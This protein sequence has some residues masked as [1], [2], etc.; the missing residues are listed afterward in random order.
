ML[1]PRQRWLAVTVAALA[2]ALLTARLGWWQLDRAAQKWAVQAA[3]DERSRLPAIDGTA[4]LALDSSAAVDQVHHLLQVSGRWSAAHTVF[5][6]NRQMK[7]RPGFY[8]V[9]PLL[10][11]DGS[12]LLVQRGWLPRDF[13]QRSRIAVVP[14]PGGELLA[15]GRIA[16]PPAR[17]YEFGAS[18]GGAI[19]QNIDLDALARETGLRLRPMS[20]LLADSPAS[21]GDGLQRDWPV[22]SSGMA[23][24]RGYAVQWFS[25]SA[26][27]LGLYVWFQLVRPRRRRRS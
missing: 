24:N 12:A 19:R 4:Q 15:R 9:T 5:L 22:P 3:I 1:S 2:M 8:V 18:E 25:L 11:A 6:D 7:G 27:I 26:L 17:L 23:K 10:L 20:L 14:T 16:P 13:Q 21:A